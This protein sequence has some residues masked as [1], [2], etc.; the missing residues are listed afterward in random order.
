[1]KSTRLKILATVLLSFGFCT[2]AQAGYPCHP[3]ECNYSN[4]CTDGCSDSDGFTKKSLI[5]EGV[6]L[7]AG[8]NFR[9]VG[10]VEVLEKERVIESLVSTSESDSFP[11]CL[12]GC[13]GEESCCP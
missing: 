2:F 6:E 1:M 11:G 7:E 9:M 12:I 5:G 4:M 8:D 13:G 10:V 3:L